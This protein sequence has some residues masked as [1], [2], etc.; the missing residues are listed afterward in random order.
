MTSEN[1]A[2]F[3]PRPSNGRAWVVGIA[4]GVLALFI[5]PLA[6]AGGEIPLP[7]TIFLLIVA[8][9]ATAPLF[10]VAWYSPLITYIV[11]QE[12]ITLSMGRMMH[13]TIRFEEI[14][15]IE[16]RPKLS[17]SLLSAFRF[18]GLAVF[19]VDY[20]DANRVR[21]LAT[22]ASKN[23]LLIDTATKRYGITPADE[24]AFLDAI[25]HRLPD[26]AEIVE[27]AADREQRGDDVGS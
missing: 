25:S 3:K 16:R 11:G 1:E 7:L 24:S 22:S 20:V 9:A 17:V 10:A 26:E 23:L 27:S 8:F 6:I 5:I 4:S 2:Q 14:S 21:M 18:P 13:D 15:R 19:D 12:S